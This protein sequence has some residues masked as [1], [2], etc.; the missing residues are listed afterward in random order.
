MANLKTLNLAELHQAIRDD[1][2]AAFPELKTV[3]CYRDDEEGGRELKQADMPACLIEL[4]RFDEA[5]A[6]DD[7][8]GRQ[9]VTLHFSA[10]LLIGFRE[11]K[12]KRSIR[13]L[14]AALAA[15]LKGRRWTDP[16][17]G[18]MPTEGAVFQ[19]AEPDAFSPRQDQFEVW[20][21][22]WT[23]VA[24][25]GAPVLEAEERPTRIFVGID[26]YTGPDHV[27]DYVE[28]AA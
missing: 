19:T 4:E 1:I 8:T 7:G 21:V 22:E 27:G 15:W 18:K 14:A 10:R 6:A 28:L 12:A 24:S 16:A 17:G 5:D 2:A 11:Q 20:R 26:P 13:L 25:L 3:D 9:R 23:Q